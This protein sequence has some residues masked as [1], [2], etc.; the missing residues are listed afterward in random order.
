MQRWK[1]LKWAIFEED[2]RPTQKKRRQ[3]KKRQN[4]IC[5]KHDFTMR[6]RFRI[7]SQIGVCSFDKNATSG[8]EQKKK[9]FREFLMDSS[10]FWVMMIMIV[11]DVKGWSE[12]DRFVCIRTIAISVSMKWSIV[13][14]L[15]FV[16]SHMERQGWLVLWVPVHY[17]PTFLLVSRRFPKWVCLFWFFFLGIAHRTCSVHR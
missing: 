6:C 13:S 2:R 7:T 3:R 10:F 17:A 16:K 1:W 11:C 9:T 8:F 4:K 15:S 12:D 5:I 14:M